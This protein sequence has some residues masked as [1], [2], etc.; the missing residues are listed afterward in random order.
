[1]DRVI[2]VTGST[3]F[4]GQ[5]VTKK[6]LDE[7]YSVYA[8]VRNAEKLKN[9]FPEYNNNLIPIEIKNPE[10]KDSKFY[11]KLI[12]DYNINSVIHIAAITGEKSI[13]WNEYYKTNVLWAKNLA[14]GFVSA[15][16]NHNT[17]IFTSTV[18]VYGTIPKYL[19]ADENHPYNPDGKYHKSK[20]LA[21]KELLAIKNKYDFPLVIFRPTILYG[22]GDKGFLYKIFRLVE[23]GLFIL[24]GNPKINLVDVETFAISC[25][26]VINAC[27][28]AISDCIFNIADKP[29]GLKDL[30]SYISNINGGRYCSLPKH[31]GK[32][33]VSICPTEVL[34]IKAKLI[35]HSW[36]Y[37]NRKACE[38]FDIEFGETLSHLKKYVNWYLK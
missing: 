1:M 16:I 34:K 17:F 20:V 31:F 7:G 38:Y 23:K 11:S 27:D 15:N 9:L 3:G 29:I 22:N 36:Y 18:G 5:N 28:S 25:L 10:E 30:L 32:F 24:F 8:I 13:S 21:E 33:L 37:N 6:L 12:T 35:T 2:L 14:Y 26:K 19:P 4:V